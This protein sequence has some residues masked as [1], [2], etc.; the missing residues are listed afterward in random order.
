MMMIRGTCF[1]LGSWPSGRPARH[2][3]TLSATHTPATPSV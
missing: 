3:R 1:F 2:P